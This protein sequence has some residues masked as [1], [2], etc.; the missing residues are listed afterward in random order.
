MNNPFHVTAQPDN[1]GFEEFFAAYI[2]AALWSTTD[3][4]HEEFPELSDNL[5]GNFQGVASEFEGDLYWQLQ[6]DAKVFFDRYH[7][8]FDGR[9]G[10]AGHDF[11]LTRNGHGVG[12]EDGDWPE[13]V[14]TVLEDAAK[15]WDEIYLDATGGPDNGM[16]ESMSV[17]EPPPPAPVAPS[18]PPERPLSDPIAE[19][20]EIV[21]AMNNP[22]HLTAQ[23]RPQVGDVIFIGLEVNG[24][25]PGT[26]AKV[27]E[28]ERRTYATDLVVEF[29][30]G[31][32]GELE[33]G[34]AATEPPKFPRWSKVYQY[35]GT[36]GVIQHPSHFVPGGV[37]TGW[38]YVV[39][40]D[41]G[42]RNGD[43]DYWLE[44]DISSHPAPR[45]SRND[46]LSDMSFEGEE[47]VIAS[48][49]PFHVTAQPAQQ[50]QM[51]KFKTG[52]L[53]YFVMDYGQAKA[54]TEVT[55][56]RPSMRSFIPTYLVT[57]MNGR[58]YQDVPEFDLADKKPRFKV[59]EDVVEAAYPQIQLG[60]IR[61]NKG[62]DIKNNQWIYEVR[63]PT[64]F[65][66]YVENLIAHAGN[67]TMTPTKPGQQAKFKVG[68]IIEQTIAMSPHE[69]TGDV[70]KIIEILPLG[71]NKEQVYRGQITY[72]PNK[73]EVNFYHE[74]SHGLRPFN[75]QQQEQQ[76]PPD[77]ARKDQVSDRI[78]DITLSG[79]PESTPGELDQLFAEWKQMTGRDKPRFLDGRKVAQHTT[80]AQGQPLSGFLPGD[81]VRVS[82]QQD[83]W[84]DL[85]GVVSGKDHEG[86][87]RV[88]ISGLDAPN[89]ADNPFT[90]YADQLELIDEQAKPRLT[91]DQISDQI[92][93]L[94]RQRDY[95]HDQL[96]P[97]LDQWKQ[98]TG[99]PMPRFLGG[100]KIAQQGF[101][102]N[103]V[104]YLTINH[105][106]NHRGEEFLIVAPFGQYQYE[107]QPTSGGSRRFFDYTKLT[108]QKPAFVKGDRATFGTEPVVVEQVDVYTK[109]LGWG[110]R[111][112]FMGG[113]HAGR[114]ASVDEK[115]LVSA[116]S[117]V[118]NQARFKN[119]DKA[120]IARPI[121]H[122]HKDGDG[123]EVTIVSD[124]RQRRGGDWEYLVQRP[125]KN[126][127]QLW[128][129][130]WLTSQ[131]PKYSAGDKYTDHAGDTG[132]IGSVD[133]WDSHSAEWVYEVDLDDGGTDS[134]AESEFASVKLN[135]KRTK[136]QPKQKEY[137]QRF[138]IGDRV[139]NQSGEKGSVIDIKRS[140]YGE[141]KYVV[142]FVDSDGK[143]Y[144][145][146]RWDVELEP[147]G[148]SDPS[149]KTQQEQLDQ[150]Q[151]VDPDES[152]RQDFHPSQQDLMSHIKDTGTPYFPPTPQGYRDFEE[153]LV[154]QHMQ[155]MEDMKR[156]WG[157]LIKKFGKKGKLMVRKQKDALY[158]AAMSRHMQAKDIDD[159]TVE[160][161]LGE[162]H[163]NVLHRVIRENREYW[164]HGNW[165]DVSSKVVKWMRSMGL[166]IEQ[167][168][169]DGL[170]AV[171][172]EEL[173]KK[174]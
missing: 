95:D 76:A 31:S 84:Y 162:Y 4:R 25:L 131:K 120:Y 82:D 123:D 119:G 8:Y 109:S 74:K 15:K 158:V 40:H 157:M 169:F 66:D 24:R 45:E 48:K 99:T 43:R 143:G 54:G 53:A 174:P 94:T 166:T 88:N 23:N 51:G 106:P 12:F 161:K 147:L 90:Y 156:N 140:T 20:E 144:I 103:D 59:G 130:A 173:L 42:P 68:D 28:I 142:Q 79:Q 71:P 118:Q 165:D 56:N 52:D 46:L 26:P 113:S 13:E 1:G 19:G 172:K 152:K 35:D 134:L 122:R 164:A 77:T 124:P 33:Q 101:K 50:K 127:S 135:S 97:L 57:E 62:W 138:Q 114:L 61:K 47:P 58:S 6:A 67:I 80:L 44:S 89:E 163:K 72:G 41:S 65:R 49:N 107:V 5:D 102:A 69:T 60:H 39:D 100:K 37:N 105:A 139:K 36:R 78:Y 64:G 32:T 126:T 104:V 21:I 27:V 137:P 17:I 92:W 125:G 170:F 29:D 75:G 167:D 86:R 93:D 155:Q 55:I 148:K 85:V 116:M 98:L 110:Y 151:N 108:K 73:G 117:Q 112:K 136:N 22:F 133:Y 63:L 129:D 153:Y 10:R 16:I 2:R 91:K 132:T 18:P 121:Q 160:P 11:W 14:A 154:K 141:P 159:N 115:D 146:E 111:I 7:Q 145:V 3:E 9:Y 34:Y 150:R 87:I 81:P 96:Q 83:D 30:D 168:T 128:P 171:A 70:A 149:G 38:T